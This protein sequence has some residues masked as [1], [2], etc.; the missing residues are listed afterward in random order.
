MLTDSVNMEHM[1]NANVDPTVKFFGHTMTFPFLAVF[2]L[3]YMTALMYES[4]NA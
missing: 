1:K 4:F 2:K 3:C